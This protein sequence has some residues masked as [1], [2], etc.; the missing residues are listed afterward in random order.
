MV[1]LYKSAYILGLVVL[2]KFRQTSSTSK[3]VKSLSPKKKYRV[4]A[5]S[6]INVCEAFSTAPEGD[7]LLV[8]DIS[9]IINN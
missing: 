9:I 1:L 5:K 2:F 8:L 4:Q 7:K 6:S 3:V